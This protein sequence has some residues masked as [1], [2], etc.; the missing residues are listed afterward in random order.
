[1]L[2]AIPRNPEKPEDAKDQ[3]KYVMVEWL[4]R[5]KVKLMIS[6]K[7]CGQSD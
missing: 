3:V 1:M 6:R 7:L 4:I 2:R 5:N